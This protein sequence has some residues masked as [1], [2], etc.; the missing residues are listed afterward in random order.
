M[1]LLH[2]SAGAAPP[3]TTAKPVVDTYFGTQVVDPYRWLEDASNP[4]VQAWNKAQNS[5]ARTYLDALPAREIFKKKLTVL[6]TATSPAYSDL[7]A[8]GGKLFALYNDPHFQQPMLVTLDGNASPATKRTVLDPNRLGVTGRTAID[9]FVP[10][11][12]GTLVAVSLSEGGSEN[13]TLHIY[14]A[15]TGQT[16]GETIPRVQYPTAGG[17]L[18]WAADNKSFWYTRYPGDEKPEADRHFF[19]QVY[20]HTLGANWT[21]D[22]LVLGTQDGIPRIGE[23]ALENHYAPDIVLAS[24]QKG[25]GGEWSHWVL[26]RDGKKTRIADFPD[27]IVAATLAPDHSVYMISRRNAPNGAVLKLPPGAASLASAKLIVPQSDAAIIIQDRDYPRAP[28]LTP[29]SMLVSYISGGPNQ[30]RSFSLDGHPRGILPLDATAAFDNLELVPG[31][32]VL[33]RV[34]S[35][36]RLPYYARWSAATGQIQETELAVHGAVKFDDAEVVRA[37]ATSKDGTKVPMSIVRKKGLKLDGRTPTLL[38]GYGGYGVSLEPHFLGASVRLWLD[39][40]GVYAEANIRGGAEFG[41]KWHDQG[42]LRN[43]QNVFDDF[44]AA[45]GELINLKYTDH[46]HLALSG[47][48]NGGLLMGA[49]ITQHPDLARA[50]VSAV[51]IYDMLRVELDPNGA[52]NATEFGTV[53]DP[54]QFR[55]LYAYSP[56]HH[57]AKGAKYPAVLMLTGANDGRVNPMQSRKFT[58]AL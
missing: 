32:D 46:D 51:G 10:S 33:I 44:A 36:L 1:I 2:A 21:G 6:I 17:S 27:Q 49:E 47:A 4:D 15:E 48:S 38:Y 20:F 23:V 42:R 8:A 22:P 40:G 5:Y 24:V 45:A 30:V 50:V 31:G 28:T 37:F 3:A 39:G 53:K 18:A 41:Q 55:A 9:W 54:A 7:T 43:K 58:A 57:V 14:S 13:G 19:M 56:Y 16:V 12:D 26:G 29:D 34:Q 52:F 11:H 25:D 35:Y